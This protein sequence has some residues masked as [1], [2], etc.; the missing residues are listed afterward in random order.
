MARAQS[1]DIDR[2]NDVLRQDLFDRLERSYTTSAAEASQY[3]TAFYS[4]SDEEA[5]KR[6]KESFD[7]RLNHETSGS[8]DYAGTIGVI[9]ADFNNAYEREID[10]DVFKAEFRRKRSE[11]MSSSAGSSDR[12]SEVIAIERST[13]R[14]AASIQAWERCMLRVQE[15]GVYAY[16]FRDASGAPYVV[17]MWLAGAFATT[18]PSIRVTFPQQSDGMTVVVRPVR[19]VRP[20]RLADYPEGLHD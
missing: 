3:R 12:R 15:P 10:K 19:P 8:G 16:G 20:V 6:Y 17:V 14:N 4:L 2:C 13:T 1:T 9:S 11:V 5:Y 7:S 18:H